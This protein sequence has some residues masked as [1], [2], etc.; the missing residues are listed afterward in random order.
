[1]DSGQIVAA[2]ATMI[3]AA[4][5]DDDASEEEVARLK[6]VIAE[7]TS[8]SDIDGLLDKGRARVA[9]VFAAAGDEAKLKAALT[10]LGEEVGDVAA[11]KSALELATVVAAADGLNEHEKTGLAAIRDAFGVG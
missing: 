1:M 8:W 4:S 2:V 11:R 3:L 10:A 5:A 7:R 9:T 6:G